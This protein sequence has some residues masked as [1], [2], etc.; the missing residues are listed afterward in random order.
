MT[1]LEDI[2][3]GVSLK[4]VN[5]DLEISQGGELRTVRGIENAKQGIAVL[6]RTLVG[7]NF[8]NQYM[9]FDLVGF[10]E[11][12][13]LLNNLEQETYLKMLLMQACLKDDRVVSVEEIKFL[14]NRG[15]RNMELEITLKYFNNQTI[16]IN[17]GV[18]G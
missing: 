17:T 15:E 11:N 13:A 18:I 16:Q 4:I 3:F 10:M 14:T 9:G 12:K 5:N 1:T 6:L 2:K 7:E 8:F